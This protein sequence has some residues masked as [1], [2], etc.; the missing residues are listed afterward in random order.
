MEATVLRYPDGSN[1]VFLKVCA[2]LVKM[3]E[4]QTE[5]KRNLCK[6]L[7][8]SPLAKVD[9]HGQ[10]VFQLNLISWQAQVTFSV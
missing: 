10:Q 5:R 4:F 8:D 3:G 6:T 2:G 1:I 9:E 7:G